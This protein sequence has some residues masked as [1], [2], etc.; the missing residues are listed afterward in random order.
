MESWGV[1]LTWLDSK[2]IQSSLQR[3]TV[4]DWSSSDDGVDQ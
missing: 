2:A 3:F 4:Y 1:C